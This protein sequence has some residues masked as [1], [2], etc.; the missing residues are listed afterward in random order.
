MAYDNVS[1][2]LSLKDKII[3]LA[4]AILAV[5]VIIYPD[6]VIKFFWEFLGG[7]AAVKG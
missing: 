5:L 2:K 4:V 3:W 7:L 1:V 6:V